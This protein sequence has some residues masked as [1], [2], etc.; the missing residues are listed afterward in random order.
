LNCYRP[1]WWMLKIAYKYDIPITLGSDA[2]HA[3][4]V[5]TCY[6]E[7]FAKIQEIGYNHIAVFNHY[8]M[9]MISIL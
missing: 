4:Q 2:H 9:S 3:D 5:G 8:Q 7:I 6:P 1:E